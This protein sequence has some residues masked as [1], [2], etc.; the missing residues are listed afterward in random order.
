[1][2]WSLNIEICD[3]PALLNHPAWP[4]DIG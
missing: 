2:F 4:C 3:L 1:M